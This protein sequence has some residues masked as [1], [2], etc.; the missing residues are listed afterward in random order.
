MAIDNHIER[1]FLFVTGLKYYP[2]VLGHPW[3]RRYAV[4]AN[5]GSNTLTMSSPFCLSYCCPSPIKITAVTREEEE[6]LSPE[7]SQRVWEL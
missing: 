5:F 1:L 7:E 4:D 2:I 3:L 6:F